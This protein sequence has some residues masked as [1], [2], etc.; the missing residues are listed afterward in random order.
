MSVKVMLENK[1]IRIVFLWE[2]CKSSQTRGQR[3]EYKDNG[4][5]WWNIMST[6]KPFPFQTTPCEKCGNRPRKEEGGVWKQFDKTEANKQKEMR[7]MEE[8]E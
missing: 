1:K 8:E 2:C 4:C 6:R 3:E 5:G 7:N